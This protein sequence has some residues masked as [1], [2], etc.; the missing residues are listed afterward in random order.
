M[1]I[2]I[3]ELTIKATVLNNGSATDDCGPDNKS[4]STPSDS[5]VSAIVAQ[6]VEQVINILKEKKER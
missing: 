1:P 3:R 4:S 6:C 5:Q 2:E